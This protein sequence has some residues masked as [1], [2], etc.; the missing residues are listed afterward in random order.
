VE[1]ACSLPLTIL[2]RDGQSK[3]PLRRV[4]ER[5]VPQTLTRRPKMGFGVPIDT[6]LRGELRDWAESLIDERRLAQDGLLRPEPIRATW[7]AHQD[8]HRNLQYQ[9]WGV[10]MFQAWREAQRATTARRFTP[11]EYARA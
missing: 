1:F 6:W 3:W 9:L 7:A 8:G 10:L 4:L 11:A 2:R 5:Y